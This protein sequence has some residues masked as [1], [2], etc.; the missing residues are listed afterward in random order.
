MTNEESEKRNIHLSKR[1]ENYQA[2][3]LKRR[4][5]AKSYYYKDLEENRRKAKER[6]RL[7]KPERNEYN[8]AYY[9]LNKEKINKR[10]KYYFTNRRKDDL[11]YK[12]AHCLRCR[13]GKAIH[14]NQKKGSAVKDLGCSIPELKTYLENKFTEGMSWDNWT[15]EGWHIDHIRPLASFDLTNRDEFLKACHYTNLQPLWAKDNL[16]KNNKWI[17]N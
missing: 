13:I 10:R 17:N 11:N 2:N 15:L 12:I 4:E 8:K 9:R 16:S 14:S 5:S 7:E 3:K 1:R 6:A